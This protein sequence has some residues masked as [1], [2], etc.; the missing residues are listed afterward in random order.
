[1]FLLTLLQPLSRGEVLLNETHHQ[2]N[3]KI[4]PNFLSD[5]EGWDLDTFVSG[6]NFVANLTEGSVMQQFHAELLNIDI[7]NCRNF[8]FCTMQYVKCY[9]YNMA[10]LKYDVVGTA[11]MGPECDTMAVVRP[12]LEVK[13]VRCLRVADSSVMVS[14]TVGN[15]V[16]TDAM[17]GFNTGEILKE[18][19]LKDY[20][21]PF[22]SRPSKRDDE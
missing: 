5:Y 21:S 16:A 7:P 20:V 18:K 13:K 3:P 14:M 22:H 1:M 12:D 6:F 10:F 11:K 17:I 15:T 19:W 9:I 8:K 4:V 2:S